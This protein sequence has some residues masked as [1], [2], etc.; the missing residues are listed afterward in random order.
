MEEGEKQDKGN[1][2]GIRATE[3][4]IREGS[5]RGRKTTADWTEGGMREKGAMA[6][7]DGKRQWVRRNGGIE[8]AGKRER[9]R[10]ESDRRTTAEEQ[11]KKSN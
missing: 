10:R 3:K 4:G 7:R 2:R 6:G 1:G 5:D 8:E 11:K 9:W